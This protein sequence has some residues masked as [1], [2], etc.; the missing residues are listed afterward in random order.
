MKIEK[1]NNDGIKVVLSRIDLIA[2]DIKLER[3]SPESPEIRSLLSKILKFISEETG[4]FVEEGKILMEVDKEDDAVV[5]IVTKSHRDFSIGKRRRLKSITRNSRII[6]EI[7]VFDELLMMLT[8]INEK[9]LEKMRVY[10]YKSVFYLSVPRYPSPTSIYEF[11]RR[12]RKNQ[13][14]EAILCEHGEL[15]AQNEQII[16]MAREIKKMI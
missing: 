7:S 4:I 5:I 2:L 16:A 11:S 3:I 15:I 6:F 12:C 8:E 1:L 10:R 14:A 13:V 9:F